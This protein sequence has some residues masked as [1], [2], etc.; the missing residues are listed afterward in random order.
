MGTS[1]K[2]IIGIIPARMGSSRYPGKPLEKILG[3]P[4]I[5]HCYKRAKMSKMLDEV[6]IATPNE[7]IKEYAESIGAKAVIG[8]DDHP[9]CSDI[10]A[11]VILKIEKMT[12]Q[13]T[14]IVVMLQGDEP[15]IVP[16]MIDMAVK[17]MIEDPSIEVLNLM[18]PIRSQEE[19]NDMNCPKVVVDE[20]NFAIYMSREPIP[21]RK[22]WKP[23]PKM[24]DIPMYKQV[25]IIPFR[26]DFL[27]QFNAWGRTLLEGIESIDMLRVLEKGHKVKMVYEEFKTYSVDTP[28]DLKKVEKYMSQDPLVKTYA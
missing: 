10:T 7:V 25:C 21:S 3:M 20:Q 11:E 14:D 5:G 23:T 19:H 18:A 24:S 8:R 15:M 9:G 6:Y 12:G 16:E 13:K 27:E 26:R 28:E 1:K 22:K 2:N 4:M 17:P